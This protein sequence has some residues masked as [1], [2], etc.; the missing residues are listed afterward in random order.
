MGVDDEWRGI[1][2]TFHI[3]AGVDVDPDTYRDF[4]MLTGALAVQMDL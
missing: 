3:L 2:G 4:E 1:R